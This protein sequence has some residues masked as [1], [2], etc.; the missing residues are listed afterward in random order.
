[1][2]SI[3]SD[4]ESVASDTI[5]CRTS[6]AHARDM[7]PPPSNQEQGLVRGQK[8][9]FNQR[10]NTNLDTLKGDVKALKEMVTR[11]KK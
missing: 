9:H 10:D 5:V 8:R 2:P 7:R 3:S 6:S 4:S 1:M 11:A